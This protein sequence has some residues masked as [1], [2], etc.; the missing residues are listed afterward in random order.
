MQSKRYLIFLTLGI[1]TING[2]AQRRLYDPVTKKWGYED[3]EWKVIVPAIYDEVQPK[4]PTP[5][6]P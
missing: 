3:N 4:F 1:L 6:W 2:F 5:S